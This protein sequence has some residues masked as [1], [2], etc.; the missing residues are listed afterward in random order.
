M[1]SVMLLLFCFSCFAPLY[2]ATTGW[3]SAKHLQAELVSEYQQVQPGQTLQLAL[4]FVPDEQWH[5]YWQNPGDSGLP[6]QLS[7][8]LPKGVSAGA[9][10]WPT[11]QAIAVPPLVNYGFEGQTILLSDLT[12]A[13]DYQADTLPISLKVDWLV[14]EEVC[15]PAEAEFSLV[16]PVAAKAV[17]AEDAV[18]LFQQAQQQLPQPINVSGQFYVS[19]GAFSAVLDIPAIRPISAFFVAATELV[20][21]AA[22]QQVTLNGE[23][24]LLQQP[25]NTYFSAAPQ[26]LDIVLI[27][28]DNKAYSVQLQQARS[29]GTEILITQGQQDPTAL[30]LIL[31]LAGA[32]GI[33]LNLMPCVFPVLSLKALSIA[34]HGQVRRQQQLQ[35]LWYSLGV[36]MSFVMLAILL[37]VLRS[38]GAAVG[39]GFQLQ[40]PYLVALLVYL[41]FALGLSLSG[42]VQFGLGLMNTGSAV[43][44]SGGSRGAFFTGVLA[45]VV[46]SPCTA[47]FM[48]TA[49]GY[50]VS[51]EAAIALLIF[52]ALGFGMALPF[53]LLA[54]V[55]GFSRVLPKPG[56]WMDT[57]KQWLAYPL[58]LSAVWLLWVYG[59]QSGVD[60]Q[61][62]LLIGVV[63]IA[64]ACW[65]WGRRQLSLAGNG[66]VM[67]AA[68]LLLLALALPGFAPYQQRNPADTATADQSWQSWSADTLSELR[69]QGKPVLVNMTAD[70]CITCLVNER[71]AL[72]SDSTKAALALYDVTYLKGDWTL[73]DAAITEYLRLYQRDGVPLYVLYW[74]GQ[75]PEVLPQILT[76]DTVPQALARLSRQP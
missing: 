60:A 40:N 2:A 4:H 29:A 21:H 51:Q 33:L 76:P 18:S 15:I 36:V 48:G 75:Q 66:S 39:W 64:A 5:T 68:V 20:D 11:P 13:S 53:L 55:P 9:I 3:Q 19:G 65:L 34:G 28:A 50:A 26:Q 12:I 70:W 59:R 10:K 73:R 25:L 44:D 54:L 32:G 7:W 30:W 14:C 57:L 62:M 23:Q 17:L 69:Q 47:P 8:T 74:P 49:L 1:R 16:L 27:T 41:L 45:V 72:S 63:C 52:A 46:A 56:V 22:P 61:A 58:Y 24:L 67:L 31:L 43:A 6:T 37:I 38:A 71:V 35:A 42:V